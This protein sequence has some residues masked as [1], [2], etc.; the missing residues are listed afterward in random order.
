MGVTTTPCIVKW[1]GDVCVQV[2]VSEKP[3][4][5]IGYV[6]DCKEIRVSI[7]FESFSKEACILGE[8]YLLKITEN[9]SLGLLLCP[10]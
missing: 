8:N 4:S 6:C 2:C 10:R 3:A 9:K 5:I 1:I 7:V